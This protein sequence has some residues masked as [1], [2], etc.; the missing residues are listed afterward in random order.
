MIRGAEIY[1]QYR[2]KDGRRLRGDAQK[3]GERLTG[4]RESLGRAAQPSDVYQDARSKTSPFHADV[5]AL[6]DAEAAK[7]HRLDVSRNI[8][9]AC[10]EV[11]VREVKNE[12]GTMTILETERP[13]FFH[14]PDVGFELTETIISDVDLRRRALAEVVSGLEGWR[15]RLASFE[16]LAR[17]FGEVVKKAR[18]MLDE[19]TKKA[20]APGKKKGRAGSEVARV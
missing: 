6:S 19:Q 18:D 3:C 1:P 5:F 17:P 15:G 14:V 20:D 2:W 8:L 16:E 12:D 9:N 13:L 7:A 11:E 10:I 4:L